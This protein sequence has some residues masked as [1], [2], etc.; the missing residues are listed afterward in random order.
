ML[1]VARFSSDLRAV[2]ISSFMQ[3]VEHGFPNKAS[4]VAYDPELGLLCIG[5]KTGALKM[6]P[7]SYLNMLTTVLKFLYWFSR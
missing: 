2:F 7:F 3:C 1:T 5:T 6:Y 4:A